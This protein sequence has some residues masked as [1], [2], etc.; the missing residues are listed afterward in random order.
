MLDMADAGGNRRRDSL[1]DQ[2]G[3]R[4]RTWERDGLHDGKFPF[5]MRGHREK[6]SE[7]TEHNEFY[8]RH[9]KSGKFR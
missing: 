4:H 1:R 2:D 6:T 8:S 7:R 5:M 3:G 9:H